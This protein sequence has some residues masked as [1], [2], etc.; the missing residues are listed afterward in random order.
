MQQNNPESKNKKCLKV[1]QG[2]QSTVFHI[3]SQKNTEVCESI[4]PFKTEIKLIC[5]RY[6]GLQT[7]K[8]TEMCKLL[9]KSAIR[10]EIIVKL[11]VWS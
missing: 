3:F 5:L 9:T 4:G 8:E 6:H 1:S 2:T 10:K 7:R 11:Q